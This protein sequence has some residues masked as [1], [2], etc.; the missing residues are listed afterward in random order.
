M[1]G[2]KDSV[3]L[4]GHT[5]T[6]TRRAALPSP[7]GAS[8]LA[9]I[10]A[11]QH[12]TRTTRTG[13]AAAA[14]PWHLEKKRETN[15]NDDDRDQRKKSNEPLGGLLHMLYSFATT[16][17]DICNGRERERHGGRG[18]LDTEGTCVL[19]II[20]GWTGPAAI[21]DSISI[22]HLCRPNSIVSGCSVMDG[23]PHRGKKRKKKKRGRRQLNRQCPSY[24]RKTPGPSSDLLV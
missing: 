16:Q 14:A 2:I 3:R 18:G 19:P 9:E 20:Q 10:D 21:G 8:P 24:T 1:K 4:G 17:T 22:A 11:F 13:G 15:E 5:H 12:N 6:H 23:P 7:F